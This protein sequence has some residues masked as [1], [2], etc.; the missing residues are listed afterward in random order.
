MKTH[1]AFAWVL[2]AVLAVATIFNA[3]TVYANA[4]RRRT[5]PVATPQT[6]ARIIR[7]SS[8]TYIAV[9][10]DDGNLWVVEI[11]VDDTEWWRPETTRTYMIKENVVSVA[12]SSGTLS[13]DYL[14]YLYAITSDGVLWRWGN[15]MR[16]FTNR[17]I[18]PIT[19]EVVYHSYFTGTGITIHEPPVALKEN[20]AFVVGGMA[21]SHAITTD[22]RLWAWGV[23]DR[24]QLGDGTTRFRSTPVAIMNNVVQAGTS[25]SRAWAVTAAGNLYVWGWNNASHPGGGN[26]YVTSPMRVMHGVRY[27]AQSSNFIA[28]M[29][30]IRD[31]G[32]LCGYGNMA[33][34]MIPYSSIG[35]GIFTPLLENVSA[36]WAGIDGAHAT[37][38]DGTSL[39]W[40]TLFT[41]HEDIKLA[42]PYAPVPTPLDITAFIC[43]S[44][45]LALSA[46]GD[47][48]TWAGGQFRIRPLAEFA[49][50]IF[51]IPAPPAL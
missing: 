3:T 16:H 47:I 42:P 49:R 38:E 32:T 40:G 41:G 28:T 5:T 10:R 36:I 15:D 31:D 39:M 2:F 8:M 46:T 30:I 51:T 7:S 34:E 48:I 33:Y 9:I 22:G 26:Y 17:G 20:V 43:N 23:N 29:F 45:S 11:P 18:M 44:M 50:P 4:P 35:L 6:A 12:V 25:S 1:R 14:G 21:H 37:M 27:A 24:G 19:G 13:N